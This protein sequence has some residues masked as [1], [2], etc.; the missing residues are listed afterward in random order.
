MNDLYDIALAA[1]EDAIGRADTHAD[2][3]WKEAAYRAV[4]DVAERLVD[5]TADDIWPL[6]ER[7]GESTH[8]ASALGPVFLRAAREN[9]IEQTGEM[10]QTRFARRHRKLTVWRRRQA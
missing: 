9:L 7:S 2:S 5:F 3:D 8:E 4:C 6:L 1:K 10:R